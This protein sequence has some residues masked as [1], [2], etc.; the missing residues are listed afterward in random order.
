MCEADPEKEKLLEGLSF[1]VI[2]NTQHVVQDFYNLA[3]ESPI[4][5]QSEAE[6]FHF[7]SSRFVHEL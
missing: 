4:L 3:M 2:A 1:T 7:P 6:F 5:N